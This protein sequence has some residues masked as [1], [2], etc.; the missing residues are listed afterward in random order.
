MKNKYSLSDIKKSQKSIEPWWVVFVID[1]I[2]I[3]VLWLIANYS[4]I[5]PNTVTL[6]STI[7]TVLAAISFSLGDNIYLIC[8]G[9]LYTIGYMLDCVDGKLAR[10]TSNKSILG[11][12]FDK[13]SDRWG[14][15]L[16]SV[17]LIY[18][19]FIKDL[20]PMYVW[21]GLIFL[22]AKLSYLITIEF[23]NGIDKK[24]VKKLEL[25]NKT[26]K[27][28]SKLEKFRDIFK[29]KRL[30]IFPGVEADVIVFLIAPIFG[31][32]KI[33]LIIGSAILFLVEIAK[34]AI[35]IK[36]LKSIEPPN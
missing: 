2:A 5:K 20:D 25:E 23:T 33:G 4:N 35:A 6:F 27:S 30:T 9:V 13:T 3:R 12:L 1:P 29:K 8:G 14:A 26:K 18:G 16:L 22:F 21:L 17:G 31:F 10:L 11:G 34:Y 15:F 28:Q 24:Y 19:Q 32:I 36:K 7:F